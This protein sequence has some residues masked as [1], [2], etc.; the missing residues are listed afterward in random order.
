[1]KYNNAVNS[2]AFF[3]RVAHY[4]CACYDWRYAW[5]KFNMKLSNAHDALLSLAISLTVIGLVLRFGDALDR[6]SV[7]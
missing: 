3:V 4:K 6:K 7:V 2:D 5:Y 1:M